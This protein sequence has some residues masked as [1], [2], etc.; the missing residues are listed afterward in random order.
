MQKF[1]FDFVNLLQSFIKNVAFRKILWMIVF[2]GCELNGT[3]NVKTISFIIWYPSSLKF[4]LLKAEKTIIQCNTFPGK[5]KKLIQA[6]IG[7]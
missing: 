2:L 4:S 3:A 7:Y 1:N 6:R 5:K